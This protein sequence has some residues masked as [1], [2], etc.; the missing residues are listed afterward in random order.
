MSTLKFASA[1]ALCVAL[2]GCAS[3]PNQWYLPIA[4]APQTQSAADAYWGCVGQN[5]HREIQD[6]RSWVI[7]AGAGAGIAAAA[8]AAPDEHAFMHY[9]MGQKGWVNKPGMEPPA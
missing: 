1:V 6:P 8:A 2:T 7:P 5:W 3:A 9:C 4:G